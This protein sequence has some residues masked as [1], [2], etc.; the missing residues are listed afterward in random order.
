MKNLQDSIDKQIKL[1]EEKFNDISYFSTSNN[2]G[3]PFPEAEQLIKHFLSKALRQIAD[4]AVEEV[5]LDKLYN[6]CKF[7]HIYKSSFH[8]EDFNGGAHHALDRVQGIII[9]HIKKS[10]NYLSNSSEK[11]GI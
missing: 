7:H 6:R 8:A 3:S 11:G 2:C 1:F 5:A 10:K 9:E 4:E